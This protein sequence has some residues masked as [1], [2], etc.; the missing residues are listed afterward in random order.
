[1]MSNTDSKKRE[2]ELHQRIIKTAQATDN[3]IKA[4]STDRSAAATAAQ[5]LV[6]F[7]KSAGVIVPSAEQAIRDQLATH[8]GTM[9]VAHQLVELIKSAA[10]R[11]KQNASGEQGNGRPQSFDSPGRVGRPIGKAASAA[12]VDDSENDVISK[13]AARIR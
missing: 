10:D 13:F 6:E 5:E 12:Y 4:V 2:L 11:A 1:M 8:A 9:K 7:A 3:V